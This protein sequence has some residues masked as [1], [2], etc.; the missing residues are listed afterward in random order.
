MWI[1]AF[2]IGSQKKWILRRDITIKKLHLTKLCHSHGSNKLIRGVVRSSCLPREGEPSQAAGQEPHVLWPCPIAPR[3][4]TRGLRGQP[5]VQRAL[6]KF[7]NQASTN[8]ARKS[9]CGPPEP[10][11]QQNYKRAWREGEGKGWGLGQSW[12]GAPTALGTAWAEASAEA[13]QGHDSC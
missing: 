9:V 3:W 6:A 12:N 1:Q 8:Q 10:T 5:G 11:T 4:D 7:S 2:C 13:G